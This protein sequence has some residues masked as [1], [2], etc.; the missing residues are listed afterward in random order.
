MSVSQ[1]WNPEVGFLGQGL[2]HLNFHRFCQRAFKAV[3][4]DLSSYPTHSRYQEGFFG[5]FVLLYILIEKND[6]LV[7]FFPATREIELLPLLWAF[8]LY[9]LTILGEWDCAPFGVLYSK[10]CDIDP[11][12]VV[13]KI[14]KYYTLSKKCMQMLLKGGENLQFLLQDVKEDLINWAGISC[15][16]M[17]RQVIAKMSVLPKLT[18]MLGVFR[19]FHG[20]QDVKW[21]F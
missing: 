12:Q 18:S 10:H 14:I 7:W 5:W 4:V 15:T 19:A 2:A 13:S 11:I 3:L 20:F 16:Q 17:R 9:S 21:P 8:C 6:V 1:G